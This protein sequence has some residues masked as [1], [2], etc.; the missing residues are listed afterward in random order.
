MTRKRAILPS[1]NRLPAMV[2][3]LAAALFLAAASGCRG[4]N[5]NGNADRY[6][7]A[8]YNNDNEPPA[9]GDP[10]IAAMP[11]DPAYDDPFDHSAASKGEGDVIRLRVAWGN[12]VYD[13]DA[14]EWHDYSGQMTID[15]G[16]LVLERLIAFEQGDSQVDDRMDPTRIAWTSHVLPSFDGLGVRVEPG[17]TPAA[18]NKLRLTIGAYTKDITVADLADLT[19]VEPTGL[20]DD[21]VAFASREGTDAATGF[22]YGHWRDVPRKGGGVFKGKWESASGTLMGHELGRYAYEGRLIRGKAIDTEG[23]FVALL[24][25]AFQRTN[26]DEREGTFDLDWLDADETRTGKSHGVYLHIPGSAVGFALGVWTKD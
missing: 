20:G 24:A 10:A 5:L 22:L 2:L 1:P 13:P 23:N 6:L 26:P 25:G 9:F 12:L 16:T 11:A 18:E 8:N 14:T 7:D 19:F 21:H 4:R 15:D 17:A 3:V